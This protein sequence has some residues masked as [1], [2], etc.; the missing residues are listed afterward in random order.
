MDDGSTDQEYVRIV[1]D[2]LLENREIVYKKFPDGS[3]SASRPRNEGMSLA[4][5]DLITFLDPD[6]EAVSD[7]FSV[8]LK[9]I[10]KK[11]KLDMVVG[12]IVREDNLKRNEIRYYDKAMK[13]ASQSEIADTRQ[14]LIQTNLTV[15]SIQ[16]LVVKKAIVMDI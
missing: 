7:G 6:N 2:I 5:T 1:D 3:G 8:L 11:P 4:S 15:Q 16:A 13:V 12:N 10:E 9:E 14:L